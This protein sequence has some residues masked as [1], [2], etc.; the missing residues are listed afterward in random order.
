MPDYNNSQ[1]SYENYIRHQ[2]HLKSIEKKKIRRLGFYT[3]CAL[4][5]FIF[6]Q[7]LIVILLTAFGL[8]DDYQ[9]NPLFSTGIDILV[10]VI[11][12]YIPFS[13]FGKLMKKVSGCEE[14]VPLGKSR[15]PLLSLLSIPAGL[16]IC[17]VANIFTSFLVI[18]MSF[19]GIELNSPEISQPDGAFG[20][21][22]SVI[23]VSVVAGIVEETAFRG[24]IMHTLRKHGDDFA[25]VAAACAF[26][27]MHGNLVQAPFALTVGLGLGYIAVKTG[28][29]RE[30]IIIHALNNFISTSFS[31]IMK[32]EFMS[33]EAVNALYTLIV[34][35]L[36]LIGAFCLFLF[37]LRAKKAAPFFQNTS[38][39]SSSEKAKAFLL[40]P[41]MIISVMIMLYYT[42]YFIK[43]SSK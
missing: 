29:L 40:N 12:I 16:G 7:N 26:G 25:I 3:G 31:Y 18:F 39:L 36:I 35:G 13:I 41:T 6:L 2:N 14:A 9:S 33:D 19:F 11:Q 42:S 8:L 43:V 5:L 1:N 17:M 38:L 24:Y 32:Y 15:D 21:F 34:Y 10:S 4:L 30:V 37:S 28:S 23:R 22:L 20:F 27:L